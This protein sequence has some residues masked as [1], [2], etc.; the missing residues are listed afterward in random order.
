V[1]FR[2]SAD[3]AE[4]ASLAALAGKKTTL[5]WYGVRPAESAQ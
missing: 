2:R 1:S 4:A 5:L 3:R